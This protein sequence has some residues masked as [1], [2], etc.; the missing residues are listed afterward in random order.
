MGKLSKTLVLFIFIGPT[1]KVLR[2]CKSAVQQSC[3][4]CKRFPI[5]LRNCTTY[6]N[7][8]SACVSTRQKSCIQT[9]QNKCATSAHR[10][11]KVLRLEVKNAKYLLTEHKRL[12]LIKIFRDPRSILYSRQGTKWYYRSRNNFT[13]QQDASTLCKRMEKD[14]VTV[15]KLQKLFPDRVKILQY[16]DFKDPLKLGIHLYRF[17]NMKVTQAAKILLTE[18]SSN[19]TRRGFH[20]DY[21]RY[22]L[23]WYT[24]QQIDRT[25]HN[26]LESLGL[27]IFKSKEELLNTSLDIVTGSRPYS[28]EV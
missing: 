26:V 17:L 5:R 27:W 10:V 20:P 6:G 12:K 16:E 21:F 15:Q 23:D 19:S 1:G 3:I 4:G 13:L 24:I 25:C 28:L 11:A 9:F 22:H 18:S 2:D 14:I 8:Y 7:K